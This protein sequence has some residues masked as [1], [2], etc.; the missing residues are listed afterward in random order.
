MENKR[1]VFGFRSRDVGTHIFPAETNETRDGVAVSFGRLKN[2][3]ER[4]ESHLNFAIM[5][6]MP[7]IV[8]I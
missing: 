4:R 2:F 6:L 5:S 8:S 1:S 7:G 3:G